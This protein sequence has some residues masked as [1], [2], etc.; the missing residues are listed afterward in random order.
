MMSFC[1]LLTA[2]LYLMLRSQ[3]KVD[4][5]FCVNMHLAESSYRVNGDGENQPPQNLPPQHNCLLTS[6]SSPIANSDVAPQWSQAHPVLKHLYLLSHSSP[7]LYGTNW[8]LQAC[9]Q[10]PMCTL[11]DCPKPRSSQI[12]HG[13]TQA[14]SDHA[15]H[16][17]C[18]GPYKQ[19]KF[20]TWICA[21]SGNSRCNSHMEL[22]LRKGI[23]LKTCWLHIELASTSPHPWNGLW[24][25]C[26]A[27]PHDGRLTVIFNS[28]FKSLTKQTNS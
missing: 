6:A 16:I 18:L 24:I 19:M 5:E 25:K 15:W 9:I 1:H 4:P 12:W 20:Y 26:E 28:N 22:H 7:V 2:F 27:C 17:H 10:S 21:G 3:Y 8:E 11:P 14:S 23:K 13:D